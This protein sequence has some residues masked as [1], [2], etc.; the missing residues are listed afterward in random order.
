M[1]TSILQNVRAAVSAECYRA[2]F[3]DLTVREIDGHI[4]HLSVPNRYVKHWLESHYKKE[5]LNAALVIAP[6]V[7]EVQVSVVVAPRAADS[8]MQLAQVLDQAIP[9]AA[10]AELRNARNNLSTREMNPGLSRRLPFSPAMRLESFSVGKSNRIAHSAAQSVAESP[11]TVYSP[12]FIQ[13]AQGLGKTHLL[14]GIG[15]LLIERVPALNVIYT[16][17]EEFTNAYVWG[18]Q[19]KKL[20][21][22]RAAYRS[23]DALLIDDIQFLS[24]KDRTQEEFLHTFDSLRNGHKQIVLAADV[25][26]RD[27]KRLD[28]RL[29]ARFQTGLVAR[30]DAPDQELRGTLIKEK[31]R[32]RG[33]SLPPDVGAVLASHIENNVRE[34]EGAVCKLMAL[35]A[36]EG[37]APDRELAIHALRELGY[38]R[39][40]PLTLQDILQAVVQ[41]YHVSAD[42]VRSSKRH[43][44]LVHV[45]H[46]GMYLSKLLTSQSVAD[47]G[48]FYGNRDHA[49]VLHAARKMGDLVKRDDNVRQE[50][51][52]L[53]QLLG[54]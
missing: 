29:V 19:N 40:G 11:G 24:G 45:R 2:W 54:R 50:V 9:K 15:H 1:S 4:I 46:I 13:G 38:L 30:V 6:E 33:L 42:E 21:A 27:I 7:R 18:V 25:A 23:C 35:A 39:S 34:L 28:P 43:A 37:R 36:S 52:V 49:T 22:F 26:P 48:R 20:D 31:A 3:Q 14:Q 16:S 47:I 32:S 8:S 12:L 44:S 53:R 5:L 51:Q 10:P 41:R 17:C